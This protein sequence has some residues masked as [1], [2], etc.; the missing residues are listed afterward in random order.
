MLKN[1][2]PTQTEAWKALTAHF[3]TAQDMNLKT[4]FAE[5]SE[6]FAKFSASFGSDL[7]VDYSKN[8]INEETMQHLFALA[9]EIDI[10]SAIKAMF[11][12]EKL[13]VL[14]IV[15]FFTL[16]FVTVV[17]LQCLLTGKM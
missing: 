15:L 12:G 13:T 16:H 6:R 17:I 2:N 3:E 1:I 9:N 10:K 5:D 7:L 11:S 8:L 4:L 14:K